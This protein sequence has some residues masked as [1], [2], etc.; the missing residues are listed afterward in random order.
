MQAGIWAGIAG[1]LLAF[2]LTVVYQEL[3]DLDGRVR[4]LEAAQQ[5]PEADRLPRYPRAWRPP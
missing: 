1:A 5:A 4:A 2:Y 3:R